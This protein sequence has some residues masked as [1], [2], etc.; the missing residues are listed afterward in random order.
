VPLLF[1]HLVVAAGGGGDDVAW[2]HARG[3]EE[4]RP[5]P[6]P[7]IHQLAQHVPEL[8]V[9]PPQVEH[10]GD[11]VDIEVVAAQNCKRINLLIQEIKLN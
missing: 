9:H 11:V 4:L 8:D 5:L 7:L 6:G 1:L 10:L 3:P 2:V